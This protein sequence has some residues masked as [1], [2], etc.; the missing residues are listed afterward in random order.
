[1]ECIEIP[2]VGGMGIH[3][4]NPALS[5][6]L[7]VDELTPEVLLYI[8]TEEGLK[9]VGVEYFAVN[10]GQSAPELFGHPFEG[11]MP[12]HAPDQP[13]H[14]DLHVWLWQANPDGIFTAFNPNVKC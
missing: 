4:V 7:V 6:D 11:P 5:S 3:F 1:M 8:E 2:G 13:E 14:F 12:G 10:V 9:L